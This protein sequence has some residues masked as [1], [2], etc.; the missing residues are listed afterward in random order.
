V[1]Q[2]FSTV[3]FVLLIG[4]PLGFCIFFFIFGSLVGDGLADLFSAT[5]EYR[6]VTISI[7]A[8]FLFFFLLLKAVFKQK[9]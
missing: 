4:L 1:K 9:N 6:V 7:A 5:W 8:F 2:T 3:L